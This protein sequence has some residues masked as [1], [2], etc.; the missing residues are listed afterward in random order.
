[1]AGTDNTASINLLELAKGYQ[2][3][4]ERDPRKDTG[5][6]GR[7][8]D[9]IKDALEDAQEI[10]EK[11]GH[12]FS[13]LEEELA[14]EFGKFGLQVDDKTLANPE[15]A[16]MD[17]IQSRAFSRYHRI[18]PVDGVYALN[19]KGADSLDDVITNI[20]AQQDLANQFSG[21]GRTDVHN[22]AQFLADSADRIAKNP[23]LANSPLGDIDNLQQTITDMK[24]APL[25]ISVADMSALWAQGPEKIAMLARVTATSDS[26]AVL[27]L[28]NKAYGMEADDIQQYA[29]V[30]AA[31]D[32]L[33]AKHFGGD[34]VKM[35]EFFVNNPI[36]GPVTEAPFAE[37]VSIG[38]MSVFITETK[39]ELALTAQYNIASLANT[40]EM[41]PDIAPDD[42]TAHI[43]Q[44]VEDFKNSLSEEQQNGFVSPLSEVIPIP[45]GVTWAGLDPQQVFQDQYRDFLSTLTPEQI[46]QLVDIQ[47]QAIQGGVEF[48]EVPV[49]S[50]DPAIR[51]DIDDLLNP[52]NLQP[53]PE[54]SPT[55]APADSAQTPEQIVDDAIE[56]ARIDSKAP[57]AGKPYTVEKGDALSRIV[58]E[59]YQRDDPDNPLSQSEIRELTELVREESGIKDA[60]KIFPGD[61]VTLPT[62]EQIAAIR[63]GTSDQNQELSNNSTPPSF[64]SEMAGPPALG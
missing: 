24:T 15:Q 29:E 55:T 32:E 6:I 26:E 23:E 33:A 10:I 2:Q 9:V 18:E 17:A 14:D 52:G 39:K 60:N 42:P 5:M 46:E 62:D 54:V 53:T 63:N 58:Q 61:K 50:Q 28:A 37:L 57:A 13:K 48:H 43:Q 49:V 45:E 11:Y 44:L 8:L 27:E 56:Q 22:M 3:E 21:W 31:Q 7:N 30:I 51:R 47:K 59:A 25:D 41:G 34:K 16:I 38:A 20:K 4:L 1:M 40:V 19:F 35:A 64:M 12:D 36:T